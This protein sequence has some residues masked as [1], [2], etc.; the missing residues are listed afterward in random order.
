MLIDFT[1]GNYR[2]FFAPMTLSLEATKLRAYEKS[3]DEQN[4]FQAALCHCFVARRFK[5]KCQWQT[6]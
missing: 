6:T 2:S 1:V 5:R 4:V 3:L